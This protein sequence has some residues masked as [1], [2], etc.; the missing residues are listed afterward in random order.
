M[1][2]TPCSH[3]MHHFP[4]I[5]LHVSCMSHGPHACSLLLY[6]SKLPVCGVAA[7]GQHL[8]LGYRL[9]ITTRW[10]AIANS[11]SAAV[12]LATL[13]SSPCLFRHY[14]ARLSSGNGTSVNC[15][16]QTRQSLQYALVL[17]FYRADLLRNAH[18][19]DLTNPSVAHSQSCSVKPLH[20]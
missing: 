15:R 20:P 10:T 11:L 17:A 8:I 1:H 4:C 7:C 9:L 5:M 2:A 6:R 13:H 3:T 18:N 14:D 16:A 19:A 12:L